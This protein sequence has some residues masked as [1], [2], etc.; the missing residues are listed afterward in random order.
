[1]ALRLLVVEGNVQ[2]ARAVQKTTFGKTAAESYADTL[3]M[4]A[5]GAAC[6][7]CLPADAGSNL[8]DSGGLD[9]YD[10]VVI[11]GSGLNLYDGGPEIERQ[12]E[13]A[14]AIYR[15]GAAFFGSCWGLQV[16]AAAAGGSV[17]K[18]P[19]G[20]EVGFA[21]NIHVTEAGRHH[22]L[23]AGRPAAFDAPCLHLDIV[24]LPPED[25]IILASNAHAV[26]QAAEIR[27]EGGTFWGVQYHPEYS[28]SE[29][30]AIMGRRAKM[31]TEDG[32]FASE[33]EG[34]RYCKDLR[35]LEKAPERRDIAWR[36]GLQP[37]VIDPYLRLTELRNW[38]THR[39]RPLKV[40]RGRA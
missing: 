25:A 22:P 6:D 18:N 40:L 32:I 35:V 28:L 8:P 9:G 10:G 23:L 14:R 30:A 17:M 12:I 36:L 34:R 19:L 11:T 1:M 31:L 21:R 15:S 7:I 3:C 2:E 33:E 37:E 16:A 20:R 27:Y 13:L 29:I 24:T 39:V 26:V 4:L 38:L 5:P